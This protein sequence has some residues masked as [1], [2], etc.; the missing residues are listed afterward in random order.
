MASVEEQFEQL[1]A[2][3]SYHQHYAHEIENQMRAIA[4]VE[5]E[6]NKT[7]EA[8]KSLKENNLS[9]FNLGSGIF[10]KG[11]LKQTNKLLM[12]VGANV[13]V[14]SSIEDTISFLENKKKEL[15]GAKNDL[16][17]SMEA[18]SNRL[19]EIDIEARRI[20]KEQQVKE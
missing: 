5:A 1:A 19:K 20:M 14:E 2:E 15:E 13:F 9:L 16:I 4:Q 18:I 3:A 11:E 6:I 17:K 12:N 8:L 10:V 7:I